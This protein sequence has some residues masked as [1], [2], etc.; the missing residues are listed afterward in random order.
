M[1]DEKLDLYLRKFSGIPEWHKEVIKQLHETR[2]IYNLLGRKHVF[3]DHWGDDL[4]RKGYS[5]NPQST[6]ADCTNTAMIRMFKRYPQYAIMLQVHDSLI[7]QCRPDEV[8]RA[9]KALEECFDIPL[10]ASGRVFRIPV[11]FKTSDKNW[12]DMH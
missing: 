1:A 9:K 5:F 11:D 12:G 3:F 2:T 10:K 6:V 4:F 8:D 7:V